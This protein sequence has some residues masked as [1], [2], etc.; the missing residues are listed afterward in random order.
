MEG[1]CHDSQRIADFNEEHH[2]KLCQRDLGIMRRVWLELSLRRG[3][4]RLC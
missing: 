2:G 4:Q 1:Q 3:H